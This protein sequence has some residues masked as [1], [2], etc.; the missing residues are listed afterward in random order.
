MHQAEMAEALVVAAEA[1]ASGDVPVG[2]VVVDETGR[3][4]ARERN[5]RE[6]DGDPLAHAELL[7]LHAAAAARGD[8]NLEGCTLLVTLEPCVMCAGA[9]LASRVGRLVYGA[10]DDKA[11]AVGS[12]YDVV[13]D[14]RLP[15][16]IEVVAGVRA[17]ESARL[18]TEFF[19]A[20][21]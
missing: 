5:R 8:W 15:H 18:L 11:G 14:R 10:W 1:L 4:V 13:R 6:A 16:R 20:R 3:I 19:R 2:A 7:A 21:R 9:I 17:D 12:V